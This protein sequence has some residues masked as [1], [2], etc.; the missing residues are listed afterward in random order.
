MLE[1]KIKKEVI[2]IKCNLN[3]IWCLWGAVEDRIEFLEQEYNIEGPKGED[4]PKQYAM[5]CEWR[6]KFIEI[7]RQMK[8]KK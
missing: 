1:S 8:E 6:E 7:D 2:T 5:L 3:N 4:M